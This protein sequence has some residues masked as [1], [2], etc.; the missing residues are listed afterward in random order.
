MSFCVLCMDSAVQVVSSLWDY[1]N[2]LHIPANEFPGRHNCLWCLIPSSSLKVPLAV[3]GRFK[4]RSLDSLK[5]GHKEFLSA[6][7]GDIRKAKLFNNVIDYFFEKVTTCSTT[8]ISRKL[9]IHLL[10]VHP[11]FTPLIGHLQS[12]LGFVGRCLQTVGFED[13][14]SKPWWWWWWWYL[15][16]VFSCSPTALISQISAAVSEGTGDRLRAVEHISHLKL[17]RS[18]K[19]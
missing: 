6:G 3:R 2:K 15:P 5:S 17:A 18:R 10:G 8:Y 13:G 19:Q 12:S 7:G 14:R 1:V 9:L 16:A 11:W 4:A